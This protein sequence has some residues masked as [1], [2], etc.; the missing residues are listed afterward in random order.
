MTANDNTSLRSRVWQACGQFL[1]ALIVLMLL[2]AWTLHYWQAW[3]YWLLFAAVMLPMTSYFLKHDPKLVERRM[4]AGPGAE[5]EKSQ[6]LIMTAAS[7][8]IV[9]LFVV[10]GLDHHFQ[11][12]AVPGAIVAVGDAGFVLGYVMIF[13]VLKQNSYAAATIVTGADQPVISTGAYALVR[14][15]MYAS[16]LVMFG[17]TPLALGSYWS[18]LLIVPLAAVLAWRLIDEERI[19]RRDL[20]G[21]AAYCG[22]VHYRLIPG[23]W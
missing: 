7:A 1:I 18:L 9:L 20:P 14:H 11:W 21:Y 15:P 12:S 10:P 17:F 23:L 3:L 4:V 6:K 22:K 13:F 8:C 16:A 5:T 19:L 2:P